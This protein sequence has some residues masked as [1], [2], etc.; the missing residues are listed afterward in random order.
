MGF[1]IALHMHGAELQVGVGEQALSD[2]KKPG[3]IVVNHDED[4]AQATFEQ[5]AQ[6]GFPVF[7]IFAAGARQAGEDLLFAVAA[8]AALSSARHVNS[9]MS[10][11]SRLSIF[12]PSGALPAHEVSI[13]M[14]PSLSGKV[15]F[16]SSAPRS[17]Y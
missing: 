3:K 17:S 2:G 11:L 10:N 15:G 7:E 8:Q 4:T 9:K 1:G 12:V 14:S 16:I 5:V 13:E 6:D